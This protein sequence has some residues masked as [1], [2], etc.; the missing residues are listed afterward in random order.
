MRLPALARPGPTGGASCPRCHACALEA[1]RV[2]DLARSVCPKCGGLWCDPG[3]WDETALGPRLSLPLASGDV[4]VGRP[5]ASRPATC[6]AGHDALLEVRVD[7]IQN[8]AIDVCETCGGVWFDHDEWAHLEALR[9]WQAHR[10]ALERRT[11]WGE[12][13]FQLILR[14]PIEFNIRPRR[15][16]IVTLSII[17]VSVVLQVLAFNERAAGALYLFALDVGHS[18]PLAVPVQ[19]ATHQFLHAGWLH[20]LPNMYFLYIL[21]D[22]IEDVLGRM[23][24]LLFFLACG[25]AGAAAQVAAGLANGGTMSLVG[26]SGAIAGVMAAYLVLFRRAKLT[27]MLLLWQFKLGAFVWI[28]VWL[29]LQFGAALADPAGGVTGVAW[30]AHLGG[31]AAGA[32]IVLPIRHRLTTRHA[33][34]HLLNTGRLT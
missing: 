14:L 2:G 23:P 8:L 7:G 20:L 21:G 17:A 18:P 11:T 9:Q 28:G 22:N 16:P 15:L 31:F 30:W 6:P 3:A 29:G 1:V 4:R 24:F 34:L 25:A 12:W 19:L 26:A 32:L 33:L 13:F 10:P 5:G 27:F